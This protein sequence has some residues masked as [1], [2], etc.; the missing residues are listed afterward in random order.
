[1]HDN[2]LLK[3]DSYKF[4]HWNQYPPGIELVYSYF[5]SRGGKFEEIVFFGLQY[6]LKQ[7]FEGQ[8][9]TL[10]KID[11]A[12]SLVRAHLSPD[13]AHAFNRA[14]WE[15]ILHRHGGRL[16]VSIRAVPEGTVAGKRQVLMTI[17]NT[18]PACP[19]L[20]NY[21][22]TLLV[23]IWYGTTVASQ[24]RAMKRRILGYLEKT[25]D[26]S[27]VDF[28]L[29][30][31]GFRGVSS[32]ET[33]G[34]G[35][36]AHLIAF[37][38]TD[39][40]E[41]IIFARDY[42]HEPMAG[43]SIPATEHST[44]TAW[45]ADQEVNAMR[46]YLHQYPTGTIACVS[47]SFD[48]FAACGEIWGTRLRDEV[49]RRDGCLVI[50]PDSGDPPTVLVEVLRILG[51]QFGYETN[52]KGYRVLNPKVRIIQGDMIDYA[53]IGRIL[54]AVSEAG[55]A[56]ENLS[57]G[58]GGGLLQK[59]NRDTLEFAFKTSYVEVNGQGRDVWKDPIT[60]P[61]KI[62]KRGRL[63]LVRDKPGDG[64]E[65]V[66]PDDS[67][68]DELVEVFRDGEILVDQTFDQIRNRAAVGLQ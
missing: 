26:S 25:G 51:K 53:M 66:G 43:F 20:T 7:Y 17:E 5:E 41:G 31:F 2:L 28:S 14:G 15:H 47:D 12:E 34:V 29:H 16:P 49:L 13:Q 4:S 10:E 18:D 37:R 54:T 39:T 59:L 24:S 30:D 33:A 55:W 19:W 6:Y 42:Y 63:K 40:F 45:G 8:V 68:P 11:E 46:H 9:V 52:E 21:L 36:A 65:T 67:R 3:T 58:S 50:R 44:I 27:G 22:E 61:D 1:M 35:A 48:I 60:G 64:W 56:A 38:G 62:S 32:V 23:Q 57:F